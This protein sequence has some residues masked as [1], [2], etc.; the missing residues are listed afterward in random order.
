MNN[1]H[2]ILT[3]DCLQTATTEKKKLIYSLTLHDIHLASMRQT[4]MSLNE[5]Q[6]Q[7][8]SEDT[9]SETNTPCG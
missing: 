8:V 2:I 6:T 7:L 4:T 3:A 9:V 5:T 1:K